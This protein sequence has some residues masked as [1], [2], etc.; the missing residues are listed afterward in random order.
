MRPPKSPEGANEPAMTKL[1]GTS[2][3]LLSC[4]TCLLSFSLDSVVANLCSVHI[5][6]G[7][8]VQRPT[9]HPV[10]HPGI[11]FQIFRPVLNRQTQ[12]LKRIQPLLSRPIVI[13]QQHAVLLIADPIHK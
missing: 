7:D 9:K 3:P 11:Q 2:W 1:S 12:F 13:R 5:Q 4:S 10:G 8:E 6:T